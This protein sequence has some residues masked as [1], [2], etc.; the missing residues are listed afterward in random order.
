MVWAGGQKDDMGKSPHLAR[1]G[2]S[3]FPD[4]CGSDDPLCSK[5]GFKNG[6]PTKMMAESFL[7]KAVKH[8]TVDGVSLSPKF[9][10]EVYTSKHGLLRIFQVV[11][12]SMES[13]NWIA[14]PK[15]RVCDA[16]GSWYC[17][18]QYPPALQS[19]ISKRKNFAQL[20]DFNRKGGEKSAYTRHIEAQQAAGTGGAKAK[21]TQA[22]SPTGSNQ[23]TPRKPE[24]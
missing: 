1:I 20:E 18:G 3:V 14:D 19:L 12:V 10:K 22:K 6:Q 9:F 8:K 7:Y 21:N 15:N 24:L 13:K 5:F 16:P 23:K 2:N 17:V 4:M 11:N